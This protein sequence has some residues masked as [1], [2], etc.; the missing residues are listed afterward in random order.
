MAFEFTDKN[1]QEEVLNSTGVQV[2][3]FWAEWCGPCRVVG[4]IVEGVAKDF[5]NTDVK[6]GKMNVDD[7]SVTPSQYG[8]RG[9]PTLLFFKDGKLA[10]RIVGASFDAIQ[11][12]RKIE[13]VQAKEIA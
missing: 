7:N 13:E 1:F 5:E 6:V 11:L 12:K 9:I 10:D 4:P 2:I 3:D 8:I